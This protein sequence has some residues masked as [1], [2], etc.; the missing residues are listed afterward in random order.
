MWHRL[1][2]YS[3]T[4]ILNMPQILHKLCT[5]VPGIVLKKQHYWFKNEENIDLQNCE[6]DISM[7]QYK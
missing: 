2:K 3:S 5:N 4:H 7:K 1:E 6:S